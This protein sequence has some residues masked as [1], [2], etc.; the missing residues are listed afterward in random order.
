MTPFLSIL[1]AV[2]LLIS[3]AGVFQLVGFASMVRMF[4]EGRRWWQ[5]P[6]QLASLCFFGLMVLLNPFWGPMA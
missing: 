1:W 2:G 4:P 3:I 5:F 6:A